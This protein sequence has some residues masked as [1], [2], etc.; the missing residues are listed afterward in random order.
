MKGERWKDFKLTAAFHFPPHAFLQ[1]EG[2]W[3]LRIF[4]QL[5]ISETDRN[6]CQC[7][8]NANDRQKRYKSESNQARCGDHEIPRILHEVDGLCRKVEEVRFRSK[9]Q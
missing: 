6:V 1:S 5:Q 9:D 7:V 3:E 8:L 4:S 2:G